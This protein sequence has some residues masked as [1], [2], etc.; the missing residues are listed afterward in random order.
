VDLGQA[1]DF[2]TRMIDSYLLTCQY[3]TTP[4]HLAR[5]RIHGVF[6][7]DSTLPSDP[8]T[9]ACLV[10]RRWLLESLNDLPNRTKNII[11]REVAHHTRWTANTTST[12]H[13][14]TPKSYDTT[15]LHVELHTGF[16][17]IRLVL[18]TS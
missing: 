7:P 13:P 2:S 4:S 17:E 15:P 9:S 5:F 18:P 6:L 11:G 1:D 16:Q 12:H 8:I 14:T 10:A 3:S